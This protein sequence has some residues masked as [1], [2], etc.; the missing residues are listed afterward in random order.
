MEGI[1][2]RTAPV[3]T[4]QVQPEASENVIGPPEE[5]NAA[6]GQEEG[7]QCAVCLDGKATWVFLMQHMNMG[8]WYKHSDGAKCHRGLSEYPLHSDHWSKYFPHAD[9]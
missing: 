1:G 5:E 9:H 2:S 3:G 7:A 8:G 4:Q 6:A